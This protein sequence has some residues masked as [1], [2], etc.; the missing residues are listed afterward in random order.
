MITARQGPRCLQGTEA[1]TQ[2]NPVA[3]FYSECDGQSLRVL[4]RV[5]TL[6]S[7]TSVAYSGCCWELL[8]GEKVAPGSDGQAPAG[9]LLEAAVEAMSRWIQNIAP[10]SDHGAGCVKHVGVKGREETRMSWLSRL[11]D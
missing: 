4:S 10:P 1:G 2:S 7:V 6:V 8:T 11:N 5:V 9:K 3:V